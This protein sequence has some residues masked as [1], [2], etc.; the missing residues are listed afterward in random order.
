MLEGR[1]PGRALM[2]PPGAEPTSVQLLR[3]D[4]EAIRPINNVVP[5]R[6]GPIRQLGNVLTRII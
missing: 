1:V 4:V 2:S 6:I 5:Q 3:T